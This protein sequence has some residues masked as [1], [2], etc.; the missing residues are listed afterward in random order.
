M[1]RR[2]SRR[3]EMPRDVRRLV[4][5]RRAGEVV[6]SRVTD[7]RATTVVSGD[8][9]RFALPN[10]DD[11]V[12]ATSMIALRA[13][14]PVRSL[15][16][17]FVL[18][19]VA[20]LLVTATRGAAQTTA[21]AVTA[22]FHVIDQQQ[23]PVADAEIDILSDNVHITLRT[24]PDGRLSTT[25]PERAAPYTY[26]VRKIGFEAQS[27]ELQ[28]SVASSLNVNVVL[29]RS[30]R[31]LDTVRTDAR[32]DA[33]MD[34]RSHTLNA[35]QIARS[36]RNDPDIYDALR[37]LRPSM[38][39]GQMAGCPYVQYLWINGER[40]P[41]APWEAVI[42]LQSAS[43]HVPMPHSPPNSPLTLIK[44]QFIS[45]IRYVDCWDRTLPNRD[46]YRNALYVTLKAG[47]GYDLR[48]GTYVAD[49]ASARRAG[50]IP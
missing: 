27:G 34:V 21:V 13:R 2:S 39:G 46:Y 7:D 12:Y 19:A 42:P 16:R 30:V 32:T 4:G 1:S 5:V 37:G 22:R 10:A 29:V 49:S 33:R 9:G 6:W 28:S 15:P 8:R 45:E 24:S 17:P 48:K 18:L 41:L 36:G 11:S 47:I 3:R 38:W 50:V 25:L 44:P 26:S 31:Q 14:S 20:G 43:V 35:D 40:I 23:A